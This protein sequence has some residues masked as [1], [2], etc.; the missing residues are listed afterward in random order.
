LTNIDQVYDK[1]PRK[2]KTVKPL[3]DLTWN[4]Y[5]K[6]CGNK[7]VPGMNLPFDPIAAKYAQK[8]KIKVVI[9]N[10]KKIKNLKNYLDGKSFKGTIIHS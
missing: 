2:Y 1:D 4:E 10:G 5:R 8:N 6:I 7:W 3:K 9:L